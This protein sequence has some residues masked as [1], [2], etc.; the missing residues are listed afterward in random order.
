MCDLVSDIIAIDEIIEVLKYVLKY[1]YRL[2]YI[3]YD[4]NLMRSVEDQVLTLLVDISDELDSITIYDNY[5][6]A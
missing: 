4:L 6:E 3:K 5:V 1:N 2:P